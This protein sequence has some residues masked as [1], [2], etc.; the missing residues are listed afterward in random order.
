M[1]VPLPDAARVIGP[2]LAHSIK[3]QSEYECIASLRDSKRKGQFFT[4][5]EVCVFMA[6]LLCL[7]SRAT[8]RLLDPG[9]GIGSFSAA[10]C[11]RFLDLGACRHIE[12]HLFENDPE[13]LPFLCRTMK[14][15]AKPSRNGAIF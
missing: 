10:V 11:D 3:L 5:P 15:C 2:L 7:R 8:F 6:D 12:I 14:L 1:N 13:V 4:A 9:A